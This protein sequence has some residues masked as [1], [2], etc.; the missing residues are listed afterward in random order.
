MRQIAD[1]PYLKPLFMLARALLQSNRV[2]IVGVMCKLT[3]LTEMSL[4]TLPPDIG[5]APLLL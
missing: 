5:H 2:A 4:Q 3:H 1:Y